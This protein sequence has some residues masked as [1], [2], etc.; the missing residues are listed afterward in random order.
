ML[1]TMLELQNFIPAQLHG[2]AAGP[3]IE[4]SYL[5]PNRL[6]HPFYEQTLQHNRCQPNHHRLETSVDDLLHHAEKRPGLPVRGLIFHISR[7][8][9]TLLAQM[10]A[11][12]PANVVASEAPPLDDVL[13]ASHLP[14]E[15]RIQW[16]K[17]LVSAIAQP[18]T[19]PEQACYLKLEPWQIMHFDLIREAFPHTSWV[20]LYRNPVEVLVSHQRIPGSWLVPGLLAPET[21]ALRRADWQPPHIETYWAQAIAS[22]CRVALAHA[23]E[24]EALLLNYSELPDALTGKIA[25][26]FSIPPAELP[27]MAAASQH[28]AKAPQSLHRPDSATKQ[29]AASDRLRAAADLYLSQLYEQLQATAGA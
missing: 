4:W 23:R 17:A 1:G 15:I 16:L 20:F 24:P 5:G 26:H 3:L 22:L 11:A 13:R 2:R 8:G 14:R 19:G 12:S 29:A 6:I 25:A 21:F 18:R 7:C 10:L 27:L 28:D 9:S